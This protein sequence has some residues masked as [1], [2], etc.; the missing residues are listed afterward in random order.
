MILVGS[1]LL[2]IY[3]IS[4]TFF[5]IFS[6]AFSLG[7][8][9]E[10]ER[11]RDAAQA[12]C[13]AAIEDGEVKDSQRKAAIA[14][15]QQAE[16]SAIIAQKARKE[17][18]NACRALDEAESRARIEAEAEKRQR[19][20]LME[21]LKSAMRERDVALSSSRVDD[22]QFSQL[23]AERDQM[24]ERC[25]MLEGSLNSAKESLALEN[26]RLNMM[27]LQLKNE[28][29]KNVKMSEI[30]QQRNFEKS[31]MSSKIETLESYGDRLNVELNERKRVDEN[32]ADSANKRVRQLEHEL[33]SANEQ[34]NRMKRESLQLQDQMQNA[35]R[36]TLRETDAERE[37]IV[38]QL[39]SEIDEK[40]ESILSMK[41]K[42]DESE[43]EHARFVSQ[44]DYEK[45]RADD[46]ERVVRAKNDATIDALN[47]E[48]RNEIERKEKDIQKLRSRVASQDKQLREAM[49]QLDASRRAALEAPT[50]GYRVAAT[51]RA[52]MMSSS[53]GLPP[54][55]GTVPRA[56]VRIHRSGSIVIDND[57]P[58]N[59]NGVAVP[60]TP[61]GVVG[62]GYAISDDRETIMDKLSKAE[63]SRDALAKEVASLRAR[64]DLRESIINTPDNNQ[65]PLTSSPNARRLQQ[66]QEEVKRL[67]AEA[68]QSSSSARHQ[69]NNVETAMSSLR[70]ELHN[71]N[72][73][74]D[75]LRNDIDH[76]RKQIISDEKRYQNEQKYQKEISTYKLKVSEMENALTHAQHGQATAQSQLEQATKTLRQIRAKE[77]RSDREIQRAK[78]REEDLL[79]SLE[80]V[81]KKNA[82]MEIQI[83]SLQ[84]RVRQ[85]SN[86]LQKY[87]DEGGRKMD[88]MNQ[89]E[90]KL[91]DLENELTILKNDKKLLNNQ[92]YQLKTELQNTRDI[93]LEQMKQ[94]EMQSNSNGPTSNDVDHYQKLLDSEREM[95]NELEKKVNVLENERQQLAQDMQGAAK[96][97]RLVALQKSSVTHELEQVHSAL[98]EL[99]KELIQSRS[100]NDRLRI[101]SNSVGKSNLSSIV[102]PSSND[103]DNTPTSHARVHV[104]RSGSI[105]I[106]RTD[107]SDNEP[108]APRSSSTTAAATMVPLPLS[109]GDGASASKVRVRTN[110]HGS[111]DVS[112]GAGALTTEKSKSASSSSL[113]NGSNEPWSLG[114]ESNVSSIRRGTYFGKNFDFYSFFC[115]ILVFN[116]FIILFALLSTGTYK[117]NEANT[118][119]RRHR[120]RSTVDRRFLTPAQDK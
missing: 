81:S 29:E 61:G 48:F 91:S 36:D 6:T 97:L 120:T 112:R 13:L 26:E 38:T 109:S 3:L 87:K 7:D 22:D 5:L 62:S 102:T 57:Q 16:D 98:A 64:L 96:H 56:R 105:S 66:M 78:D 30:V 88:Q 53:S 93:Q 75:Q 41:I 110:R 77:Q 39:R 52:Q 11:Q 74:N 12:K 8:A 14:R 19:I 15:A 33:Q 85:L 54:Q 71:K 42:L 84:Q 17:A 116:F 76:L 90:R 82:Q 45:R 65:S 117:Q 55:S 103:I 111:V 119:R 21:Q 115:A 46:E 113:V 51:P 9:H 31:E 107:G 72:E 27:E 34:M 28:K 23:K 37:N 83:H 4:F 80:K 86:Q 59:A 114:S 73:E 47:D 104:S 108:P 10:A 69:A 99:E 44:V 68:E 40:E 100:E 35:M 79:S 63:E 101:I 92:I 95:K 60:P 32:V 43:R 67:Q 70:L 94:I 50:E 89:K 2:C 106:T 58:M 20:A 25:S 24:I 18:E 1:S 118:K 49:K